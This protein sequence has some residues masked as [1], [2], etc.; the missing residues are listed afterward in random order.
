AVTPTATH[1]EPRK[2]LAAPFVRKLAKQRGIRLEDVAGSGPHGR[3]RISDLEAPA[4]TRT[5]PLQGMR[6]AI[7]EHM[8][9]A[10]RNAPQ[11]TSMDLLD[12]TELVR[13][14]DVLLPAAQAEGTRLT[15]LPFFVKAAVEALRVVPE[16]NA[17]VDTAHGV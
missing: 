5:I 16:A 7:A 6:R 15:Y 12:V 4:P 8:V 17:I 13:A 3:V 10:W 9:E 11:V 2:V 1:D 14:R